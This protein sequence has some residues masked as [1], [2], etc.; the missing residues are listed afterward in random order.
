MTSLLAK[1]PM[2]ARIADIIQP[3]V[4]HLGFRLVRVR[5][6]G[7][8]R[9]TLQIMAERPDGTMEVDDCADLSIH[10]SAVLDV[11]DPIDREYTLEVSSPGIDRPLTAPADFARFRGFEAR[12]ETRDLIDGRK[13][14]KGVLLGLAQDAETVRIDAENL[15]PVDLPFSAL[16]DAKLIL[17]DALIAESLK[18]RKPAQRAVD[19]AEIEIAAGDSDDLDAA[20]DAEAD[21]DPKADPTSRP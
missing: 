5:L 10:L 3:S 17:T 20:A 14:F 1:T 16:A 18:G 8:Q 12:L 19:G 4:E 15:G 11:N 6:Q 21:A 2:D 7:G 9:P 13:R